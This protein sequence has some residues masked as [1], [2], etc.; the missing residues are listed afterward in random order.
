[1]FN[2]LP[3][4]SISTWLIFYKDIFRPINSK[5]DINSKNTKHNQNYR[6]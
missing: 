1:M 5:R 4:L 2:Y 6:N 3:Q